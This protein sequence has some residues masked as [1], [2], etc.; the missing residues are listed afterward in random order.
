RPFGW[1]EVFGGFITGKRRCQGGISNR[2]YLEQ[3]FPWNDRQA[4]AKVL[5]SPRIQ[6]LDLATASNTNK[7]PAL[8][9]PSRKSHC[10]NPGASVS[11]SW[12]FRTNSRRADPN[13][14]RWALADCSEGRRRRLSRPL[15][16]R[17]AGLLRC[18]PL[19][20]QRFW[21]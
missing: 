17:A 20:V 11:E 14:K 21:L 2:G 6:H 15:M 4:G 1:P 19:S 8:L 12:A 5:P 18:S 10:E 16:G 13:Q 3:A 7:P 9:R